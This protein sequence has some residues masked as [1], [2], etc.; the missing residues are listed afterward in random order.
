MTIKEAGTPA[1]MM[2][3]PLILG[4]IG[5]VAL[6][7]AAAAVTC[8]E[9]VARFAQENGLTAAMP[10]R[11][12]EHAAGP[13][14]V[15]ATVESRGVIGTDRLADSGGVIKPP[16]TG[17]AN[18][19]TPP[20]TPDPMPTAPKMEPAPPSASGARKAPEIGAATRAQ[21][22][23]MLFAAKAAAQEG[24]QEQ[25]FERLQQAEKL[26]QPGG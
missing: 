2:L 17:A 15:P 26:L 18:I 16:D 25:C 24:K 5:S 6:T 13:V 21:V 10:E 11:P 14:T 12:P 3:K 23:A 9:T 20:P 4:L 1:G 19:I 22:E 8:E 7:T